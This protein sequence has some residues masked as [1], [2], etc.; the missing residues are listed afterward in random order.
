MNK[1]YSLLLLFFLSLTVSA[2]LIK[3]SNTG[4]QIQE[5]STSW[6]CVTD[7][8]T[9]LMWEIKT[10]SKGLQDTSNTF[11]WFDGESGVENGEYSRNC[12]WGQQCNTQKYIVELNKLNLCQS[13]NWRLPT[14]SELRSLMVF[15]NNDPLINTHYFPNTRSKP[16]WTSASDSNDINTAIDV[17]F[18]YG[19]TYGSGKSFD[20]Y[21]RAVS[22]VK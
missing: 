3:V 6:A 8:K 15:N 2:K 18:F 22:D 20:S 13:A 17:P 5:S 21:I 19:G 11:T 4:A 14:T 12:H 1:I 10:N 7:D 9:G 16:Y